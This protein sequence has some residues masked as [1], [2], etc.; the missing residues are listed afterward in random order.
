MTGAWSSNSAAQ[1]DLFPSGIDEIYVTYQYSCYKW[2]Q[3]RWWPSRLR[4]APGRRWPAPAARRCRGA[5]CTGWAGGL[6]SWN[7]ARWTG[8]PLHRQEGSETET[9]VEH[10]IKNAE[11]IKGVVEGKTRNM[12]SPLWQNVCLPVCRSLRPAH[13]RWSAACTVAVATRELWGRWRRAARCRC[14]ATATRQT[15]PEGF[16]GWLKT[17]HI[18]VH[19]HVAVAYIYFMLI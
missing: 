3:R 18:T 4:A 2:V 11:F 7:P 5:T 13:L 19:Q 12:A 8:S 17:D 14:S 15:A 16:R 10:T 9:D 6:S 1:T